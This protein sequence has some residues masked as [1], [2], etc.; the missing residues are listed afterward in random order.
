MA[1][2]EPKAYWTVLNTLSTPSQHKKVLQEASWHGEK[3]AVFC[4]LTISTTGP[5]ADLYLFL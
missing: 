3:A 2:Y 5:G 4:V 1:S